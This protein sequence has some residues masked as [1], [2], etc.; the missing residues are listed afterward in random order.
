VRSAD[1]ATPS[2]GH[3]PAPA[4]GIVATD[5]SVYYQPGY[6]ND[7]PMVRAQ[8]NRRATG[9]ESTTWSAHLAGYSGRTF[10]KALV[11]N[12]GNG[13]V[14]RE[15][16]EAG[17]IKE[18]VGVDYADDLL[19]SAR[20]EAAKQR[21]PLRYSR[22]DTNTAR[23]PEDGFDLVI[24]HAAGHHIAYLDRVFRS[25]AEMLPEDGVFVS[26]DYVGAHR[27]QYPTAQWE[28]TW[29]ANEQLPV[30]YRQDLTYPHL[31]TMLVTDPTEA[32]HA[33]LILPVLRRYFSFE[34]FRALGGGIAYPVLTFNKGVFDGTDAAKAAIAQVLAT[35][36][37]YTDA[38]PERNTL[39]AYIIAQPRKPVLSDAA[40]L[41]SW[42]S[43]EEERERG[44]AANGGRYYPDTFC[45]ALYE[46]LDVAQRTADGRTAE[47]DAAIDRIHVLEADL[48][49][50]HWH[51]TRIGP[52][53]RLWSDRRLRRA[54]GRIP[55]AR[56]VAR[57]LRRS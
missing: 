23:W 21:L 15:L 17:L 43:A 20:E 11:L 34:Y 29:L 24:N 22:L 37:A 42:T 7:L 50:P 9:D 49:K 41:A 33:E 5:S 28:A 38:D 4:A 45:S 36:E 55:G 14:E 31:P 52:L 27:N 40:Q 6:W 10:A 53:R 1:A 47:R 12:C 30:G 56:R 39:F 51:P 35:D 13:W 44:A 16:V 8:L 54:V 18:A 2:A 25:I 26:W 32:I 3:Q 57:F 46:R 19:V 48:A